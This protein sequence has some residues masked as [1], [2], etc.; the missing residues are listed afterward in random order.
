MN[1]LPRITHNLTTTTIKPSFLLYARNLHHIHLT[2][3]PDGKCGTNNV[4]YNTVHCVWQNHS[5]V[6]MRCKFVKMLIFH[7]TL[8]KIKHSGRLVQQGIDAVTADLH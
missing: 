3:A 1:E 2:L 7:I 6:A 5:L 8:P 4:V